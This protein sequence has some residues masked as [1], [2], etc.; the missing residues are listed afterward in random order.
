MKKTLITLITLLLT[1]CSVD[2]VTESV[3]PYH[4]EDKVETLRIPQAVDHNQEN[5]VM[6]QVWFIRNTGGRRSSPI[7]ITFV[8]WN[9]VTH[10]AWL[11][12]RDAGIQLQVKDDLILDIN[13]QASGFSEP[14]TYEL[15]KG[16]QFPA[17][18]IAQNF[19]DD[20]LW[21]NGGYNSNVVGYTLYWQ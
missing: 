16:F 14:T 1:S 10:T 18:P 15:V 4:T 2:T 20:W 21:G 5:P 8:D 13:V 9:G 6:K 19:Y 11:H 17:A 3:T 12:N 7:N